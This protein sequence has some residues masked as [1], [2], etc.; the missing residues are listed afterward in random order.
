ML[1]CSNL[2]VVRLSKHHQRCCKGFCGKQV[3]MVQCGCWEEPHGTTPAIL[4]GGKESRLV[5]IK[6]GILPNSP[7]VSEVDGFSGWDR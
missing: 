6:P 7:K 5:R 4:S 1:W 3:S 2:R